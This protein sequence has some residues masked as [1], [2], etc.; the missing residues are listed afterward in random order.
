MGWW[1][2]VRE[3]QLFWSRTSLETT[4]YG[5]MFKWFEHAQFLGYANRTVERI[6][7]L[8]K[9]IFN[10]GYS[11]D[12]LVGELIDSV[13]VLTAPQ[14]SW[15]KEWVL[16]IGFS[17]LSNDMI[18]MHAR[19]RSASITPDSCV[20]A[21][22]LNYVIRGPPQSV[23]MVVGALRI[24]M[25]PDRFSAASIEANS[26]IENGLVSAQQLRVVKAAWEAGWYNNPRSLKMADL[27]REIDLS[28]STVSEHLN[29]V[30][31][32]LV[33]LLLKSVGDLNDISPIEEDIPIDFMWTNIHP[34]DFE[35]VRRMTD[36]AIENHT[37]NRILFRTKRFNSDEYRLIRTTGTPHYDEDGKYTKMIGTIEDLEGHADASEVMK[38][39]MKL[40]NQHSETE[41]YHSYGVW[42]WD[43]IEDR[44]E[45]SDK[46]K[47]MVGVKPGFDPSGTAF[48]DL[49]SPVFLKQIRNKKEDALRTLESFEVEFEMIRPDNGEVV[50][51]RAIGSV[52][53]NEVGEAIRIMGLA[54]D[55]TRLSKSE[56][57]YQHTLMGDQ[58]NLSGDFGTYEVNA[59]NRTMTL[60]AA[61]RRILST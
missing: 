54:S 13:E 56:R 46:L 47:E 32:E 51:V 3:V 8:A 42:N 45:W 1:E 39:T 44:F 19:A 59:L 30:E 23:G 18:A 52:A 38:L 43:I 21:S 14:S 11:P 12:D 61:A 31:T 4:G 2:S 17:S 36:E 29:R 27:A 57:I 10:D 22:G 15:S 25:K 41:K 50:I 5:I 49:L 16:Q 28:R 6:D 48:Y 26:I 37:Q 35:M 55:V 24:A 58:Q 53:S 7:I 20:D 40:A 34:D 33:K 60:S 9:V